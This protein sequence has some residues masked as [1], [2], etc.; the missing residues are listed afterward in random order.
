MR[1]DNSFKVIYK[2]FNKLHSKTNLF[3][4][5]ISSTVACTEPKKWDE[6]FLECVLTSRSPSIVIGAS[7]AATLWRQPATL[8]WPGHNALQ[9]PNYQ[10]GI[11]VNYFLTGWKW[12]PV[13][14]YQNRRHSTSYQIRN[15]AQCL[16]ADKAYLEDAIALP[17]SFKDT[18]A[19]VN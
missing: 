11:T 1:L 6:D 12:D 10:M 17:P 3:F 19:F 16:S 18:H 9:L 5:T 7:W 15:F 14:Q 8:I 4:R 2:L 13:I